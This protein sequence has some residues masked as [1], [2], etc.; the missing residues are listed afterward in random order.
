[1]KSSALYGL[2]ALASA[3]FLGLSIAKKIP[4]GW[5]EVV[6]FVTGAWCVWLTVKENI[7]NWPIGLANATFSGIVY[8]QARLFAD[9]VLQ[10]VYFV[11]GLFGW[12]WWLFGGQNRTELRVERAPAREL[13]VTFAVGYTATFAIYML[14]KHFNGAAPVLD[15]VLTSFSLVA[16][17]LLTRKYLE[18]WIV[19]IAVDL[20]YIPWL[21]SRGLFLMALLYGV[22]LVLAIIGLFDWWEKWKAQQATIPA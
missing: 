9:S 10:G 12:Y 1:M 22:F 19:W 15:A 11:V 6:A 17:F 4:M 18:N 8:F 13:A 2:A 16:Q 3:T 20:V 5:T 7:W 14:L 21:A